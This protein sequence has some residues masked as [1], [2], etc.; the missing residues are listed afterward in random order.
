MRALGL[1]ALVALVML[2][3]A[4]LYG[5][6]PAVVSQRLLQERG[7]S[8]VVLVG[9]Q[10]RNGGQGQVAVTARLVT[11]ASGETA[12]ETTEYVSLDPHERVALRIQLEPAARGPYRPSVKVRYPP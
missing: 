8:Y 3:G 1:L 6:D 12:A 10:N 9:I 7:G 2:A 5:P 4:C 11:R